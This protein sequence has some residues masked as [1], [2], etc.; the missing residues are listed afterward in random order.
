MPSADDRIRRRPMAAARR[1]SLIRREIRESVSPAALDLMLAGAGRISEGNV[2]GRH[3]FGST[4]LT[5]ELDRVTG[6]VR[7]PCDVSTASRVAALMAADTR[8]LDRVIE[9]AAREAR[10]ICARELE[11]VET[12]VRVRTEGA[13]IYLDVD[14]EG[15]VATPAEANDGT[16][17]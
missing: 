8:V 4:M 12:D 3:Y 16:R 14:I 11:I 2:S 10:R 7:E 6:Q 17:A 5:V 13:V 15:Q 1:I 9:V